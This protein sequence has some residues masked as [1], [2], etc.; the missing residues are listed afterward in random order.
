MLAEAQSYF[1]AMEVHVYE[2]AGHAFAND[3]RPTDYIDDAAWKAHA[4]TEAFLAEHI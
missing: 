4:R 1:P 3:A 2:G